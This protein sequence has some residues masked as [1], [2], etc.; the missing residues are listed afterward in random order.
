MATYNANINGDNSGLLSNFSTAT[1]NAETIHTITDGTAS[2]HC[3][4][5]QPTNFYTKTANNSSVTGIDLVDDMF[6]VKDIQ[7]HLIRGVTNGNFFQEN[8][9]EE[10]GTSYIGFAGL[11]STIDALIGSASKVNFLGLGTEGTFAAIKAAV[12][13]TLKA[14]IDHVVCQEL[15]N[16][17]PS[18]TFSGFNLPSAETITQ[19]TMSDAGPEFY[20]TSGD[21][22]FTDFGD[23][24]DSGWAEIRDSATFEPT[25]GTRINLVSS[26][27]SSYISKAL[28]D[29]ADR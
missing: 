20:F 24:D 13:D 6:G 17:I 28:T 11:I 14:K 12:S 15:V 18:G 22:G 27:A 19:T 4:V 9:K 8:G 23:A 2:E 25:S 29:F 5:F 21:P 16:K 26:F 7:L 1:S 10:D 3:F